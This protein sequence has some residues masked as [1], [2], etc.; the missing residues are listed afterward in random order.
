[1]LFQGGLGAVELVQAGQ[2]AGEV[3]V[4]PAVLLHTI[5][6]DPHPQVVPGDAGVDPSEGNG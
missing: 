4:F 5:I 3:L 1:M 2:G 6:L